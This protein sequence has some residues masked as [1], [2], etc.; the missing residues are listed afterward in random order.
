MMRT[1]LR[2]LGKETAVFH[3]YLFMVVVYG[4]LSGM[5]IALTAPIVSSLFM[6]NQREALLWLATALTGSLVC[7]LWRRRLE[8]AGVDVGIAILSAGR[9]QIGHSIAALPVG[10][11]TPAHTAK[12]NHSL[13]QGVMEVAQLPAHVFTPVLGGLI[14][15]PIVAIGLCF[16]H[17]PVGAIALGSLPLMAGVF[18]LAGRLG[19]KASRDWHETSAQVSQRAVEFAQNQ[20]VMRAFG[21]ENSTR[22]IH[23]AIE[24]QNESG[25]K[26]I[27]QS[28]LSVVLNIWVLQTVFALLL[29]VAVTNL[30]LS[31]DHAIAT[32]VSLLLVVR[33]CE[34]LQDVAAYA[35]ALRGARA[36]LATI[37]Q[38]FSASP[39]PEP[40]TPLS[41]VDNSVELKNVSFRYQAQKPPALTDV[42]LRIGAGE[43]VA[44]IGPSGSGKS[45][46][47][48]LISRFYDVDA[49]Q[50]FI[51]GVDVQQIANLQLAQQL[52]HIFQ[53]SWL[54]QGSVADNIRLGR[55]DATD[56]EIAAVATSVGLDPMLARMPQGFDTQVGESGSSLSGG[57]RQRIAIARALLKN[58]PILIVDEATASL[59]AQNQATIVQ[60]IAS[61]RGSRTLIVIA[62]QLETIRMADQIVV[63]DHGRI[64][65]AGPASA[66]LADPESAYARLMQKGDRH[67]G[68]R[69]A[70]K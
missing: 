60:T 36:Q 6:G 29:V 51:G 34:P 68:W 12:L 47:V 30:G 59:D 57:E 41:P 35:E 67:S 46:L 14:V 70:V 26:L 27:R 48:Q 37:A 63:L 56:A 66:L 39:L 15:P 10:W 11:F 61:L 55:E 3:R 69:A 64:V 4:L 28:V 40:Q 44:I 53:N 21:S 20:A 38:L 54:F 65:E 1:F 7:W 13:T 42:D 18:L 23:D 31:K 8:M 9:H 2:L 58:A 62:H 5:S 17:W 24:N 50:V 19:S 49:G 32:I 52:G 45:T 22:F 43:M 16:Y 33:F 25:L